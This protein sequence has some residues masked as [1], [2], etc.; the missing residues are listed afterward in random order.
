VKLSQFERQKEIRKK[1]NKEVIARM[2]RG[3]DLHA[4]SAEDSWYPERPVIE[5]DKKIIERLK[6]RSKSKKEEKIKNS[7]VLVLSP[8][9]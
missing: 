9:S 4:Y 2:V 7:K 5:K 1:H 3:E 6:R 8:A